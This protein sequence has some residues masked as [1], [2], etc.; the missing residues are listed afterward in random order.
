MDRS[1]SL[2]LPS[3]VDG[4]QEIKTTTSLLFVGANGSGKTRLGTWIELQSSQQEKVHRISAQKSLTVPDTTVA[5]GMPVTRHPPRRSGRALL[6]HPAPTSS[7]GV[8]AFLRVRMNNARRWQPV[9]RDAHETSPIQ[10]LP[11]AS[12]A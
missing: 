5:V 10:P 2:I 8:E 11:L 7:S 4:T 9:A 1:F 3:N 6:T 12:S